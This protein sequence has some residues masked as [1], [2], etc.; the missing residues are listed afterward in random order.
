MTERP[1]KRIHKERPEGLLGHLRG[2]EQDVPCKGNI[3][4][5]GPEGKGC[6]AALQAGRASSF[7]TQYALYNVATQKSE[8]ICLQGV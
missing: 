4:H 3:M 2:Q 6:R 1:W 5:E 8:R 7:A